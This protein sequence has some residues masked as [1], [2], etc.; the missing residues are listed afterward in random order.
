MTVLDGLAV[1]S[2]ALAAYAGLHRGLLI[3]GLSLT[4]I[5]AGALIGGTAAPR[6]LPSGVDSPYAPLAAFGG[7]IVLGFVFAGIASVAGGGLLGRVPLRSLRVVDSAGGLVL[8]AGVGLAL[9]WALGVV[10]LHLP[11]HG[12]LRQA[13]QRSIV[14]R[15]LNSLVPPRRLIRGLHRVDP[16]PAMAGPAASVEAPNPNVLLRPG[17]RRA[18]RSAVRVLG[19]ACGLG[20]A[21]SGWVA[22]PNL[23]VTAAHVVAG[24][25]DTAVVTRDGDGRPATAVYF[26]VRNDLAV[27]RV[28]GLAEE[29][30]VLAKPRYGDP[31]AILGYPG[32]GDFESKPG[33]IART[34]VILGRDAY[35]DGPVARTVTVF[36]GRVGRGNSGGPAVNARGQ[37]T[38]TVFAAHVDGV[39]GHGVPTDVIRR[40]L[41]R[42]GNA[43]STGRCAS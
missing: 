37:V 42:S 31:V 27:L 9:V 30:L 25:D 12:E 23:V 17:V 26:D 18:A 10:M 38:T 35:G 16:F 7:A 39:S 41:A 36:R 15:E 14:L 2:A 24:Q 4:G 8:G 29:P 5:A 40:A 21:G 43:V 28:R 13:V 1:A 11:G 19:T 34:T 20:V 3:T 6:L 33:R 32:D 22:R